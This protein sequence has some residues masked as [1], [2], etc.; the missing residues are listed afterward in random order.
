ML[1]VFVSFVVFGSS[2][3]LARPPPKTLAKEWLDAEE[4]Y[5]KEQKI[6]PLTGI[7]KEY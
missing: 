2:R 3:L 7:S 5:L 6:E 4:V 1:G